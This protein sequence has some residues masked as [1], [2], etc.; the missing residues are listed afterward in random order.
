MSRKLSIFSHILKSLHP[1]SDC[2]QQIWGFAQWTSSTR[3]LPA[4][5]SV[6]S[7]NQVFA[8]QH[9][10]SGPAR[11]YNLEKCRKELEKSCSDYQ[12]RGNSFPPTPRSTPCTN[13]ATTHQQ[14]FAKQ[15]K[16]ARFQTGQS[17]NETSH[18]PPKVKRCPFQYNEKELRQRAHHI[19]TYSLQASRLRLQPPVS[20]SDPF[21]G[22]TGHDFS[23]DYHNDSSNTKDFTPRRHPTLHRQNLTQDEFIAIRDAATRIASRCA[24]PDKR[25]YPD[26]PTQETLHRMRSS[27][28]LK[29]TQNG[30]GK[31]AEPSSPEEKQDDNGI[32]FTEDGCII[33]RGFD[34]SPMTS[35]PVNNVHSRCDS[36]FGTSSKTTQHNSSTPKARQEPLRPNV[37]N[38]RGA[39]VPVCFR[40]QDIVHQRKVSH[41]SAL[42]SDHDSP[43]GQPK[44]QRDAQK[45]VHQAHM[46]QQ[47]HRMP[48]PARPLIF[49]SGSSSSGAVVF[50]SDDDD[51]SDE[52]QEE[53][54]VERTDS[55]TT[56]VCAEEAK[57]MTSAGHGSVVTPVVT[58]KPAETVETSYRLPPRS[59][60]PS[61]PSSKLPVPSP[62]QVERVQPLHAGTLLPQRLSK[63]PNLPSE[64]QR[65]AS[66]RPPPPQQGTPRPQFLRSQQT[67]RVF[68]A[69]QQRRRAQRP[70]PP[71]A[72]SPCQEL[73]VLLPPPNYC[74][75]SDSESDNNVSALLGKIEKNG[76]RR[77]ANFSWDHVAPMHGFSSCSAFYVLD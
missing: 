77:S 23:N 16:K 50:D 72:K 31:S 6:Q 36:G 9:M 25:P 3:R 12:N 47:R 29:K 56:S 70:L 73:A 8:V 28:W 48:V 53:N 27:I 39:R 64:H 49:F 32:S 38:R 76:G 20:A 59:A 45:D 61:P 14:Q 35:S 40:K 69:H 33:Q 11:K 41:L 43:T 17:L 21:D 1:G 13:S 74:I 71:R 57:D 52:E 60:P 68:L 5:V 55:V 62:P 51:D 44:E 7:S 65:Q 18:A 10:I 46:V 34:I 19:R 58:N 2:R 26:P 30:A 42:F 24:V 75:D 4:K 22:Y 66:S 67:A 54:E 37:R 63:H 15:E